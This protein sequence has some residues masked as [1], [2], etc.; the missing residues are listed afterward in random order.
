[1][2][3]LKKGLNLPISGK[4]EL[5][6]QDA[7]S[8][9]KIAVVGSDYNF[10]KPTMNVNEG[11]TVK[12]GQLLFSDK[13]VEGVLF[14]AP[15]S[16]KVV[17][18]NRG[19]R[20][21]FQSV[22][23]ETAGEDHVEFKSFNSSDINSLD[24]EK[25]KSL[26]VESGEWSSIRT[27][28]FSVSA[29]LDSKPHSVFVTAMDTNPLAGNPNIWI[30]ENLDAFNDGV[31]IVSK[32]TDGK[33]Y[34]CAGKDTMLS[35]YS[36]SNINLET[37]SGPHPAGNAGTHIHFLDAV[38]ENKTVWHIGY[39]DVVAIGNLFKTGKLFTDRLISIAGPAA[40]HPRLVRVQ[41]GSSLNDILDGEL[42]E[43]EIRTISGSVFNGRSAS[44][45][46]GF[47]GR[48]HNQITLLNEGRTREFLGW[49]TPGLHR[50]SVKPI[51]LS[52]LFGQKT[53]DFTTTTNGSVRSIVPI[54]SYE[55]VMPLD[56]L[57]TFLLRSLMSRDTEEA[58]KLGCLELDEEDLALCTFVDPCKNEFGPV[59]R[60]NL[61]SIM[62]D[63]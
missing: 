42:G 4:P 17:A 37:F 61:M 2:F 49:H 11:D 3:K 40:T 15:A 55:K 46:L 18:V 23:I 31:K 43:G 52:K 57:P 53:F 44:G 45:A 24:Y 51:Y 8:A 13:K 25:V 20:R 54:G 28:P 6:T 38:G 58:Q 41:S 34:V 48:F 35:S 12:K 27:R 29:P 9:K 21:A 1:M 16:G 63:G 26:L 19:A 30:K 39:Q 50:F 14:T 56:I 36:E 10:M 32:L 5:N 22:V 59:L 47:L 60:E 7:K 33:T 62:K